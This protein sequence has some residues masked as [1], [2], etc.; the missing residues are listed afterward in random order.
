MLG[1]P[2]EAFDVTEYFLKSSGSRIKF[3]CILRKS[4]NFPGTTA[5]YNLSTVLSL[6][7]SERK[8]TVWVLEAI[9]MQPVVLESRRWTIPGRRRTG[10]VNERRKIDSK[11]EVEGGGYAKG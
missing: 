3:A 10:E 6:N 1:L 11:G 2:S 4:V 7:C 5:R 8:D 9:M